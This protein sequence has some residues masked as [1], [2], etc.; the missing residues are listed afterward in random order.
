MIDTKKIREENRF[1]FPTSAFAI[2]EAIDEVC[3]RGGI[4]KELCN[5]VDWLRDRDNRIQTICDNQFKRIDQLRKEAKE[6][7]RKRTHDADENLRD[8]LI[9]VQRK[10]H[11]KDEREL[12]QEELRKENIKLRTDLAIARN[13]N[14]RHQ[15]DDLHRE[16]SALK[17]D[18]TCYRSGITDKENEIK[19][20][21]KQ[22]ESLQ[23]E[24]DYYLNRISQ[25]KKSAYMPCANLKARE[26][27]TKAIQ[28]SITSRGSWDSGNEDYLRQALRK[29]GAI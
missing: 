16:I 29:W 13:L 20:C 23:R 24:N 19:Q 9:D 27:L 18:K 28:E 10:W 11:L 12:L 17:A 3:K 2:S 4:I 7:Q 25:L 8:V 15:Q 5:E 21:R 14:L 26:E 6:Q 1:A 22:N